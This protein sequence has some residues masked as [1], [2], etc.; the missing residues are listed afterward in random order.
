MNSRKTSRLTAMA[1]A[2]LVV[3]ALAASVVLTSSA[4]SIDYLAASISPAANFNGNSGNFQLINSVAGGSQITFTLNIS[5]NT[6]GNTTTYPRTV[7]FGA[8]NGSSA[9]ATLSPSSCTFASSSSTCALGVTVTAPTTPGTYHVKVVD[10][11]GTGGR[12]GLS[13]GGGVMVHFVVGGGAPPEGC[14]PQASTM[15]VDKV[16]A[17]LH[18]NTPVTLKATLTPAFAGKNVVFTVD[19]NAAGSALTDGSGV[20]SVSYNVSTLPVGDHTIV[21]TFAGDCDLAPA[22]NSNT[23]GITYGAVRFQQPIN[24]DGS[25][26]FKSVRTIPVKILV[27]D[28]NNVPVTDAQAFVFFA[29]YSGTIL[30]TDT[31]ALPLAGTNADSG[32]QMRLADASIGQY[33]F[34]WDTTG[35]GSGTFRIRIDLGE[36][37]C[38]DPHVVDISFKR[39]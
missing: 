22:S 3:S 32:N 35:L 2:F 20:A 38:A 7:T 5:I 29:M 39:K 30:G 18:Q 19:G 14:T 31:E 15:T 10:T 24:A 27:T 21:A 23:L 37:S 9:P 16:C 12:N 26:I 36:G 6:N 28:A 34:N 17:I 8:N 33:I 11:D 1:A 25:S 13:G 4:H